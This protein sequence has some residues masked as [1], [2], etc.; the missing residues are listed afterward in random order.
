MFTRIFSIL[1]SFIAIII[2]F[3][4]NAILVSTFLTFVVLVLDTHQWEWMRKIL[5]WLGRPVNQDNAL[6]IFFYI[7]L[8]LPILL[9]PTRLMACMLA[10]FNG[11]HKACA[12]E[13]DY[14]QS[15]IDKI[16]AR[17]NQKRK[18]Y[19]FYIDETSEINAAAFGINNILVTRGTMIAAKQTPGLLEGLLAHEMGHLTYG[20]SFVLSFIL[21]METCGIAS[22]HILDKLNWLFAE[23]LSRIPLLGLAFV[24]VSFCISAI[25]IVLGL[26]NKIT[27]YIILWFLRQ[28]EHAADE[29]ACKI[30]FGN[31]L[32]HDLELL[33]KEPMSQD[34]KGLLTNINN[35]H[36]SLPHRIETIKKYLE[37]H[38]QNHSHIY[39]N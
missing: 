39:H 18:E 36:P 15:Y 11:W 37:K 30:G 5:Q 29:Y 19:H 28:D 4:S 12:E 31:E 17:N 21:V 35:D 33:E 23:V 10:K 1:R 24:L 20:H 16:I 34:K 2:S 27:D 32:L 3:I 25:F 13:K 7:F 22:G 8:I 6:V 14:I 38:P 26:F 9:S